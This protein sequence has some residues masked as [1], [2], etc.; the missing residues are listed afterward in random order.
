MA[1]PTYLEVQ[2]MVQDIF[3]DPQIEQNVYDETAT[4]NYLLKRALIKDSSYQIRRKVQYDKLQENVEWFKD[5]DK[6]TTIQKNIRTVAVY[7]WANVK[8]SEDIA[9]TVFNQEMSAESQIQQLGELKA[10]IMRDLVKGVN[11]AAHTA[12]TAGDDQMW[13]I[14]DIIDDADPAAGTCG[15]AT[16]VGDGTIWKA[17]DNGTVS[18]CSPDTLHATLGIPLKVKG[19]VDAYL[20]NIYVEGDLFKDYSG[21]QRFATLGA[22]GEWSWGPA[23]KYLVVA[24]KPLIIDSQVAGTGYGTADSRIYAFNNR[25]LNL[26]I[27]KRNNFVVTIVPPDRNYESYHVRVSLTCQ[28]TTN[29]R[30]RLGVMKVV[31]PVQP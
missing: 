16:A 6:L 30:N 15:L 7:D 22:D 2:A 28:L 24:G 9:K 23:G 29:G 27:S 18:G 17:V 26:V 12:R 1:D 14:P 25:N 8:A 20:S 21:N 11:A 4:A 3:L 13:S 31:N 5:F 19:E 10:S